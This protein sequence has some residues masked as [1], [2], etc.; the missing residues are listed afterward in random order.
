MSTFQSTVLRFPPA[1]RKMVSLRLLCWFK[2]NHLLSSKSSTRDL[3]LSTKRSLGYSTQHWHFLAAAPLLY[4]LDF[5]LHHVCML[6]GNEPTRAS[7][8]AA[9]AQHGSCRYFFF[10]GKHAA[11]CGSS[12]LLLVLAPVLFGLSTESCLC[13]L[14]HSHL[15]GEK[16]QNG[17]SIANL[18]SC[19]TNA[20][21]G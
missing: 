2:L 16:Q 14:P 7:I 4:L 12:E 1:R 17:W 13:G 11:D 10:A 9:S 20:D 18:F 8:S 21:Y 5:S 3:S 19:V 15:A 6:G